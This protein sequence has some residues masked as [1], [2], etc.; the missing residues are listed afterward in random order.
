MYNFKR[1]IYKDKE[2]NVFMKRKGLK[3]F[4]FLFVL[5]FFITSVSAGN[6]IFRDGK[7]ISSGNVSTDDKFVGDGSKL[8]NLTTSGNPFNQ[9]LNTS[10]DVTFRNLTTQNISS[11][12]IYVTSSRPGEG[13]FIKG[14]QSA[15]NSPSIRLGNE[16]TDITTIGLALANGH[17]N[18]M[19][20]LYDT[21]VRIG[22]NNFILA[23]NDSDTLLFS[24]NKKNINITNN[25][26]AKSAHFTER[27][28]S[29]YFIGD[30]SKLTNLSGNVS[31]AGTSTYFPKWASSNTLINSIILQSAS[32]FIGVGSGSPTSILH[33]NESTSEN[34][35][36]HGFTI[37][38]SGSG[39]VVLQFLKTA[40]RRWVMGIDASDGNSFKLSATGNLSTDDFLRVDTNGNFKMNGTINSTKDVCVVNGVCL[41]KTIQVNVANKVEASLVF[42][43]G[44]EWTVT[45]ITP[46]ADDVLT[47]CGPPVG[48]TW[49]GGGE[50][51]PV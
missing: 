9:N 8:T 43:N 10:N 12:N 46:G 25:V 40:Q 15:L 45:S 51:C 17:Y 49:I 32:G 39:D 34:T 33:I 14:I 16:T 41:N 42:Y 1:K 35:I 47:Y 36:N 18:T 50:A 29:P 11:K 24:E 19:A 27:V 5:S 21:I 13:I 3:S 7:I 4:V 48:L 31:G 38:Q 22:E 28:T 20:K 30:G 26:S 37:E 2:A 44:T 23:I 6:V